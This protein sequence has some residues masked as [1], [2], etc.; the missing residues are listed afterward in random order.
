MRSVGFDHQP[1]DGTQKL[2]LKNNFVQLSSFKKHVKISYP[3]LKKLTERYLQKIEKFYFIHID[4]LCNVIKKEKLLDSV[5]IR[6]LNLIK[7]NQGVC[8]K[9][10]NLINYLLC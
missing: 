10:V 4:D 3:K 5:A 9:I 1:W 2:K 7:V 8:K 6:D